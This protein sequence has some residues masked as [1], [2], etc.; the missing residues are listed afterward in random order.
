MAFCR[1]CGA[2]LDENAKF[3]AYCGTKTTDSFRDSAKRAADD[4][5]EKMKDFSNTTDT[6]AEYDSA[7]IKNNTAYAVL[8]YL[9]IL[10]LVPIFA[11]KESR[12]ARF[13]A[14]QGLILVIFEAAWSV[15][16]SM[17]TAALAIIGIFPLFAF[18]LNLANIAFLVLM[19]L[20]IVNAATGK[21][22][23]LPIIG[24][25]RILK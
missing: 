12:Y 13:H 22:R 15:I 9:G 6:S 14:N 19:I 7:D 18:L 20:G 25:I 10:V 21:A 3:C 8:A 16:T 24:K 4:F 11:A 23:E 17:V 1:G 2:P 5:A